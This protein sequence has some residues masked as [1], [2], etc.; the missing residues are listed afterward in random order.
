M[1][2]A[3]L[4]CCHMHLKVIF[5]LEFAMAKVQ[6]LSNSLGAEQVKLMCILIVGYALTN[7]DPM[8]GIFGNV[9]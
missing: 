5:L 7:W 1:E 3:M 9:H 6:Q 2:L 4:N 8:S